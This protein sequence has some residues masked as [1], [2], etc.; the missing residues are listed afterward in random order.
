MEQ[1]AKKDA[2]RVFQL[3]L[4]AAPPPSI[5]EG[6]NNT[7][8]QNASQLHNSQ[9][10]T[11][12]TEKNHAP[13]PRQQTLTRHQFQQA[14][15]SISTQIHYPTILPLSL[16]MLLVGSS[17]GVIS[18]IMPF[19]GAKLSLSSSQYGAVVSSF[20][21]S[22][23][24]GNVPFSILV[25]RHGRRPYL[26]HSLWGVG[27]GVMGMGV[28]ADWTQLCGC[29]MTVGLGVA[30]LVTASSECISFLVLQ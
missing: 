13:T 6:S 24:L 3:L 29:R 4:E 12:S 17:V 18:P 15:T 26:V 7:R 19:L 1:S 22:K 2:E 21:F 11:T 20:A 14:L 25:D 23:M 10:S 16:S 8:G 28:A 30:A 27:L 9:N 5:M